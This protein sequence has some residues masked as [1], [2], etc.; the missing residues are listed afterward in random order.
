MVK[1]IGNTFL[2]SMTSAPS[3]LM[4]TCEAPTADETASKTAHRHT[5]NRVKMGAFMKPCLFSARSRQNLLHQFAFH[6]R[7]PKIAALETICELLVIEADAMKDRRMQVM[8]MNTVLRN[9]KAQLI[10][11]AD[12]HAAFDAAPGK[13]HCEG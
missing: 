12:R 3:A 6:I 4:V 5:V 7:Q 11:F 9:V 8:D 10:R 2:P 1:P 13:P